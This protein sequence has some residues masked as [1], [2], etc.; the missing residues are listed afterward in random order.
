MRRNCG[1]QVFA[2]KLTNPRKM[3]PSSLSLVEMNVGRFLDRP[4]LSRHA[5]H[6]DDD[7]DDDALPH[8]SRQ[9]SPTPSP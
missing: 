8:L 5:S 9:F 6:D 3:A 2:Y 1:H 4:M 7:D